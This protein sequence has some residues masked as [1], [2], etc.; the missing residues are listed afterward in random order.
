[1][2]VHDPELDQLITR[3]SSTDPPTWF[4]AWNSLNSWDIDEDGRLKETLAEQYREVTSI[5]GV[6]IYLADG[7]ERDLGSPPDVTCP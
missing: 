3:L 7:V 6:E 1:M 5:C 2:R 4:I